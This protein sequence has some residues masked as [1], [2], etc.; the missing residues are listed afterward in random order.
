MAPKALT[1]FLSLADHDS[2]ETSH[3]PMFVCDRP[4]ECLSGDGVVLTVM[5]RIFPSMNTLGNCVA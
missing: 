3:R 1:M 4:I 2:L 5:Q